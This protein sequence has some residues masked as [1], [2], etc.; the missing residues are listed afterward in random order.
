MTPLPPVPPHV[1]ADFPDL[2]PAEYAAAYRE[3][4][5]RAV[6][7]LTALIVEREI[8]AAGKAAKQATEAA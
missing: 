3:V 2:T 6:R 7:G 8:A 5:D 1:L 4:C